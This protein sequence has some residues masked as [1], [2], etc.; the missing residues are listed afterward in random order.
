ML[1][2]VS[3]VEFFNDAGGAEDGINFVAAI[4][5]LSETGL[6]NL[7][8]LVH[9]ATE[10]M[11]AHDSIEEKVREVPVGEYEVLRARNPNYPRPLLV[12]DRAERGVGYSVDERDLKVYKGWKRNRKKR[13]LDPDWPTEQER[14]AYWRGADA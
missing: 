9:A 3:L 13:G 8:C 12:H 5:G 1:E 11:T 7:E 4:R 14:D 10:T 6:R 2:D